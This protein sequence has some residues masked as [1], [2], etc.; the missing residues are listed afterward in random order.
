MKKGRKPK[1]VAINTK[2]RITETYDRM[3]KERVFA[4]G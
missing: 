4:E 3:T 1:S 2:Q